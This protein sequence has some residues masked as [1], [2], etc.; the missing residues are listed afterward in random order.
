MA[1]INQIIATIP[2]SYEIV[3][4]AIAGILATE[5]ANQRT[6]L[7]AVIATPPTGYT[8]TAEILALEC[9][10]DKIYEERITLPNVAE[11]S[12]YVYVNVMFSGRKP[13]DMVVDSGQAGMAVFVVEFWAKSKASTNFP[14]GEKSAIRLQRALGTIS[15][16]LHSKEYK[17]FGID[18]KLGIFGGRNA[19]EI[20]IVQPEY[21]AESSEHQIQGSLIIPVKLNDKTPNETYTGIIDGI[22]YSLKVDNGS[23]IA[24]STNF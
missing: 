11:M 8:P 19:T 21:G 23:V 9:L 1:K 5:I 12:P 16:I 15:H 17:T 4:S 6:L 22:D 3:R 24:W 10:P 20:Q 13:S 7:N 14:N 2:Q 18:P